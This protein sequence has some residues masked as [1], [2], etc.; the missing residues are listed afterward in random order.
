MTRVFLRDGFQYDGNQTKFTFTSTNL[1]LKAEFVTT[2]QDVCDF[3][4]QLAP[5]RLAEDW[6][7]VG[8]LAGD[9]RSAANKIMTC[10]T[11]TPA[12]TAEA[13]ERGA[14]MIVSHH[15]LPFRAL[16]RITTDQI[17]SRMLWQLIRSNV[18]IYSP[19]TGFDSATVGINQML[20][21]LIGL[22]ET[23]PL[24]PIADDVDGLGS[25]RVGT[26]ST[27]TFGDLIAICKQQFGLEGLHIVGAT[28]NKTQK[29][30]IACGSGGSFLSK[31]ISAG[32]DTF[33]TGET[34]FHTCLEA[35]SSGVNL[36]LLGHYSSE[37][38]AI[39]VLAEKLS[40]HFSDM[41]V[42]AS[43]KESDPLKWV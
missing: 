8:L 29:V 32:C 1:F 30:A 28:E 27:N 23:Q 7:N 15:P 17:P 13:I 26:A 37:R 10:L 18:A 40:S 21:D 9:S 19:H 39:E 4:D 22:S 43:E 34:T 11:I 16:K 24:N 41:E 6:D 12:S 2:I 42:W 35:E 5:T 3:L 14:H 25:G 31:A 36:L 38:F 20:A 33:I